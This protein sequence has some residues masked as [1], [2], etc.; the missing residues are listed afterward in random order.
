M[1]EIFNLSSYSTVSTVNASDPV[2]QDNS[3]EERWLSG[4][5]AVNTVVM[6]NG[7]ERKFKTL[8]L[9]NTVAPVASAYLTE[10]P[11]VSQSVNYAIYAWRI[12][13]GR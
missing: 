12:V 1:S 5:D 11:P 2:V 9:S 3:L 7:D 8:K 6:W 10:D 4:R 13:D